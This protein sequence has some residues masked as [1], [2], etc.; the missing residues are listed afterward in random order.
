M[1]TVIC[2]YSCHHGNTR[3]VAQAM[4]EECGATL[5]DLSART[6]PSLEEYDLIGFA[7]GIYGFSLHPSVVQAA[8]ER[9]PRGKRVF[10]VYTYGG[11]K[12]MGAKEIARVAQE[13]DCAM[14]GEFG[15]RGY[16]TFGPF[17]LVG[18]TGKGKPDENDL[19]RARAFMRGILDRTQPGDA[20]R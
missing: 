6:E 7:S 3:K 5:V 10:C 17:K 13:K 18:G 2:Y 8:R 19:Q 9:L 12:G 11:A 4:A 16:N 1:K 15:C 20:A 14:L